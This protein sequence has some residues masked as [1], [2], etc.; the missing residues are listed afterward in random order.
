MASNPKTGFLATFAVGTNEL[1][2]I[3][4]TI[5]QTTQKVDSTSSKSG[6]YPIPLTTYLGFMA[7]MVFNTDFSN[8]TFS[9]GPTIGVQTVLT[10]LNF[11]QLQAGGRGALGTITT[12]SS[13]TN[14]G[15][16]ATLGTVLD[17]TDGV[18][19]AGTAIQRYSMIVQCYGV[20]TTPY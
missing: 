6:I 1:D 20:I 17:I 5:R 4:W 10:N 11:Y 3:S 8:P 2:T 18:N 14:P 16:T 12:P 13:N 15:W 9:G 7:T 19:V